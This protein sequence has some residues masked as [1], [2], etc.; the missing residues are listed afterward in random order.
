MNG[1]T[2]HDKMLYIKY[3][4][5]NHEDVS[6]YIFSAITPVE[7][8]SN[9]TFEALYF[10]FYKW[11]VENYQLITKEYRGRCRNCSGDRPAFPYL[12]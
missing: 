3:L 1:L 8:T 12:D 2:R 10:L 6:D 9:D 4:L 5:E 11:M 7:E